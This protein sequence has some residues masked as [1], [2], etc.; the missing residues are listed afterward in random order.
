MHPMLQ[1]IID[2]E[3]YQKP[4]EIRHEDVPT[5]TRFSGVT[6]RN[7]GIFDDATTQLIADVQVMER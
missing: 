3:Q 2:D 5:H 1:R 7:F 4:R 6:Q